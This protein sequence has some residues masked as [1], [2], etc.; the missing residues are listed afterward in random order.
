MLTHTRDITMHPFMH[1]RYP[2]LIAAA[3]DVSMNRHIY[4]QQD[5]HAS[6]DTNVKKD[7]HCARCGCSLLF[8]LD[9][10]PFVKPSLM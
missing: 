5:L 6:A 10:H 9:S 3:K 2:A 8:W 4:G 7:E 1:K